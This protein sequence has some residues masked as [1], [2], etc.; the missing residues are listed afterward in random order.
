MADLQKPNA[1]D[2]RLD[3]G[4]VPREW[5]GGAS[6]VG[7][8][9]YTDQ[10]GLK[11][12]AEQALDLLQRRKWIIVATALLVLLGTATYTYTQTPE[13][14]TSSLVFLDLKK[15]V[16]SQ[17]EQPQVSPQGETESGTLFALSGRS[18][19]TE[20]TILRNSE[21]LRR[22]VA[23]RLVEQG[24]ASQLLHSTNESK[25]E[26]LFDRIGSTVGSLLDGDGD[27]AS[28]SS[29]A[30]D[31]ADV[32]PATVAAA[33]AGRVQFATAD[34]EGNM[35]QI[36]ARDED[37]EMAAR[38]ANL[39]MDEYVAFTRQASR[40][41]LT[42]ARSF[43]EEQARQRKQ[44]LQAT[45]QKIEAY[46]QQQGAF[47]LDQEESR[48]V[49]QIAQ[50]ETQRG[51]ARVELQMKRSSLK[52]LQQELDSIRPDRLSER[53]GS[54]IEQEIDALQ[55]TIAKLELSKQ[56]LQ[57]KAGTLTPSDSTQLAQIEGRIQKLRSQVSRLSDEYVDEIM[58]SG[59]SADEGVQRVKDLRSQIADV[60]IE[61]SGLEARIDVLSDRLQEYEA[62]LQSIPEQSMALAQLERQRTHAQQMYDY[63]VDQL[64]QT[65]I[66]EKTELGYAEEVA[67]ASVP[68]VPVR[69][70]P[71]R[72]LILGLLLG[73]L[74][75]IGGA[76]VR[77]QL[78]NRVYKPDRLN[79][80]GYRE[81]G[82]IP[83][84]TP[85]IEDQLEGK[86]TVERNGHQ[87][88]S[89]VI[90]AAKPHS[91]A[92]EAFR[93]LRTNV[94]FGRVKN[95]ATTFL[96]TSPGAGDG[97]SVTAANLAVVMAEAGQSTL[98]IDADLHRP[99]VHKLFGMSRSPGLVEALKNNHLHEHVNTP[100]IDDLC[101]LPAG[102]RLDRPSEVLGSSQLEGLLR[103]AK[104]VF[105]VILLDTSPVLATSDAPLLATHCDATLCVVR[106]GMTTEAELNDAMKALEEV[107]AHVLGAVFNGF[108]VSMAYGYTFRYRDYGPYGPY[109]DYR[110]LPSSDEA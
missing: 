27:S 20:L 28:P 53:V 86:A 16:S 36:T 103:G 104:K 1:G 18:L 17:G 54:S 30:Q 78:D 26:R 15:L 87:L 84:L 14:R 81:I 64:Q 94:Q 90:S 108:D 38:L 40:S 56:E 8:G 10:R 69:P 92:A 70:R 46:K 68:G 2:G 4:D 33:V 109:D 101:V 11:D 67:E 63:V 44:E 65:R 13:Y 95:G 74:G 85:I 24:V 35:I 55:S 83:N 59:L 22:N 42:A 34:R 76:L 48:L 106:A 71:R 29:Q 45:E 73:L 51:E 79:D 52:S 80:L 32:P 89:S 47:A 19:R 66:Q 25:A 61:I 49:N 99:R 105:D 98:L 57:L 21:G 62:R 6:G 37:P 39:Y 58:A 97:K 31:R 7:G 110:S 3:A 96:V 100:L 88:E 93:H 50:L 77:D 75:G 72:N 5:T 82:V 91:A 107:D 23:E 12:H 9:Y 102:E 60:R 41:Q 43:L